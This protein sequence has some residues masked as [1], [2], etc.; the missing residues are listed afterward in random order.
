[1]LRSLSGSTLSVSARPRARPMADARAAPEDAPRMR[2]AQAL[3]AEPTRGG[4]RLAAAAVITLNVLLPVIEVWRVA[5]PPETF[6]LTG[7]TLAALV[8][9]VCAV[10]L[11]LRHVMY[12]LRGER[13]PAA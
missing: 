6:N 12:A 8:A 10:P 11:H 13:P 5:L 7:S 3:S 2:L 1:M 4:V 9:T